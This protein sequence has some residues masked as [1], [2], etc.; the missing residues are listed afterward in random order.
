MNSA[1]YWTVCFRNTIPPTTQKHTM[2][3]TECRGRVQTGTEYDSSDTCHPDS[4]AERFGFHFYATTFHCRLW[5]PVTADT[6]LTGCVMSLHFS[7]YLNPAEKTAQCLFPVLNVKSLFLW[8]S[9]HDGPVT[10]HSSFSQ[11]GS[12]QFLAVLWTLPL[13]PS[14]PLR[15][16][17]ER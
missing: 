14:P 5:L 4:G 9:V 13:F 2:K 7:V 15:L 12:S 3:H 16:A 10:S 17:E 1:L 6:P 8:K 11:Y